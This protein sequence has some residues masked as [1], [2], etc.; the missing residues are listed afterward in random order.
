MDL[1]IEL[2]E[3]F[4]DRVGL[5]VWLRNF[6]DQ[7][8]LFQYGNIVRA[9]RT[10]KYVYLYVPREKLKEIRQSLQRAHFVRRVQSSNIEHLNFETEHAKSLMQQLSLDAKKFNE[11][12]RQAR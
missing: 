9:S 12:E 2:G 8:K 4:S 11:K 3:K 7:K 6:N 10:M 5:V 1:K